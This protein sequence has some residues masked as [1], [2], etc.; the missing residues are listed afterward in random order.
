MTE[1][2]TDE[3]P[4]GSGIPV[5]HQGELDESIRDTLHIALPYEPLTDRFALAA[6]AMRVEER[7]PDGVLGA[8]LMIRTAGWRSLPNLPDELARD[9]D[10]EDAFLGMATR[11][12]SNYVEYLSG[13]R[14]LYDTN[15]FQREEHR[16]YRMEY[17]LQGT[18]E[19]LLKAV[20]ELRR[21]NDIRWKKAHMM[22]GYAP[23]GEEHSDARAHELL[24]RMYG[25][26]TA[27]QWTQETREYD[28]RLADYYQKHTLVNIPSRPNPAIQQDLHW[29]L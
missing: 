26:G 2:H 29:N 7:W 15:S 24:D 19:Q 20:H 10:I 3:R 8:R 16:A 22:L 27:E 4:F 25:P 23:G 6:V 9:E 28:E 18:P 21:A 1:P 13:A 5:I 11:L 12:P 14:I 17:R